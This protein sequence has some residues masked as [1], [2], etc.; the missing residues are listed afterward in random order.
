MAKIVGAIRAEDEGMHMPS[1]DPAFSENMLFTF[2]GA[3]GAP[4]G[5]VRIGNRINEGFAEVTFCL[6]LPDGSLL[7]RFERAP[8]QDGSKFDSAGMRFEVLEP[9]ERLRTTFEGEAYHFANPGLL[10]N[11]KHAYMTSPM[12]PVRF[13]VT[14][15][16]ASVMFMPPYP[17]HYEQHML[18]RGTLTYG[19]K[20]LDIDAKG[21]RDHTWGPRHWQPPEPSGDES[22]PTGMADRTLWCTFEAGF[23]FS[24]SLTWR[25]EDDT[26]EVIGGIATFDEL[27]AIKDA[28]LR[29]EYQDDGL[30]HRGFEL[31]IDLE[32]GQSFKINAATDAVA[33]L[34]NRRG[35]TTY[36]GQGMSRYVFGERQA[37]GLSEYMDLLVD[38][39]RSLHID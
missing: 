14:H 28:R 1:G 12:V 26:P 35:R 21:V 16:A 29:S 39:G 24:I 19:G 18:T 7:F 25:S 9:T 36:I 33:P 10:V 3:A 13:D 8:I 27:I 2:F 17:N 38:G 15:T 37:Y 11:P 32:D 4:G 20:T 31:E 30:T 34:R 6:F 5:L 23:G 22:A